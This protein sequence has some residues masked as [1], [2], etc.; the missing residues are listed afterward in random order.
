MILFK[1][2][3]KNCI[4]FNEISKNFK[5]DYSNI[6]II[7]FYKTKNRSINIKIYI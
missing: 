2:L 3:K 7:S 6:N 1:F 4:I 5:A